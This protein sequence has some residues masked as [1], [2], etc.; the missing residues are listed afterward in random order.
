MSSLW[1]R[2]NECRQRD[3]IKLFT[4]LS[5][6]C[7]E[8][9]RELGVDNESM[10]SYGL[11]IRSQQEM[12]GNQLLCADGKMDS[13][14]QGVCARIIRNIKQDRSEAARKQ[15]MQNAI[16]TSRRMRE[17]P[18]EQAKLCAILDTNYRRAAN[19]YKK[20]IGTEDK[21]SALMKSFDKSASKLLGQDGVVHN[22]MMHERINEMATFNRLPSQYRSFHEM[23]SEDPEDELETQQ[24][25]ECA[26]C[27]INCKNTS[28][29][30]SVI[31]QATTTRKPMEP[32]PSWDHSNFDTNFM[33]DDALPSV[34]IGL[35]AP[36]ND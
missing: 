30:A 13:I 35:A 33:S 36:T 25:I 2:R 6:T 1:Q 16:N 4:S 7:D 21:P 32:P 20:L 12:L 31:G 8:Q 27:T 10:D 9:L 34:P 14:N 11:S 3:N 18:L 17:Q 19:N 15:H 5:A 28:G 24:I 29:I 23:G 26:L 22:D